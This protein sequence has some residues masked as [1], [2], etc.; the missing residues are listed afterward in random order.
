VN[1]YYMP[2]LNEIVFPA[3][4]LQPPF[5]DL[6]ADDA[7]NYGAIGA[8]IGHEIGHGFDDMGSTFDGDGVMRNWWTDEDK[9]A[10]EERTGMLVEQ[11][12]A[13]Q[14]F[15]DL[16]VNGEF[17]LGE[18]IGDL[19]GITIGLLAYQ[20][21]LN[22]EE[23]PVIDG[24]TGVQRVFLGFGQV[25]RGKYREEALRLQIETNPHSPSEYRANGSV[26]NVPEFYAA[27]DVS[28]DD[29]LYLA[30]GDRVKIW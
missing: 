27:F 11:Y 22:G 14:P 23:A 4:I 25:W 15:D 9:A 1:A 24:F 30:P 20:M 26:R 10:F 7:V 5:F 19:G 3:A 18:N 6:E 28:P 13:F 17:T 8:V 12:S 29:A 21:S 16:S 2:P